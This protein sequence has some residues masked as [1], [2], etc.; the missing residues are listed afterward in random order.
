MIAACADANKARFTAQQLHKSV[1]LWW[2]NYHAILLADH[3]VTWEEFKI[4]FWG[5]HIPEGLLERKLNEFLD[6]MH[7]NRIVH[8]YAHAFNNM[9]QYVGYHA[10]TDVKKRD[11]F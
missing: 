9:C 4:A 2:D 8:Q 5:H 7:G 11:C 1:R 6:L 3:V 10:N